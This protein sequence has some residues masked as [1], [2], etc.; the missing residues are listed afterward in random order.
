MFELSSC[1]LSFNLATD[2]EVAAVSEASIEEAAVAAAARPGVDT[3]FISCTSLRTCRA[4][5]RAERRTGKPVTSS[6][7]AMAWHILRLLGHTTDLSSQYGSLFSKPLPVTTS[8][9]PE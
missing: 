4:A 8:G 3:V 1:L 7:M 6:N 2:P 9:Q 5:A